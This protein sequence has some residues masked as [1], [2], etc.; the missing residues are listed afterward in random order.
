MSPPKGA[1]HPRAW[2]LV[3]GSGARGR[4]NGKVRVR[5]C[6]DAKSVIHAYAVGQN[7]N[8]GK[9]GEAAAKWTS[10]MPWYV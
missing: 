2:I 8:Y 3:P 9:M 4:T 7:H 6:S 5:N 10:H 1:R